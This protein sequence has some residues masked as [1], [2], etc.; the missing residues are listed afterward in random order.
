MS[1]L[2]CG[3]D[4]TIFVMVWVKPSF[5]VCLGAFWFVVLTC[6]GCI[7]G[8][9]GQWAGLETL[10]VFPIYLFD[11][12]SYF[13]S[14]FKS[15]ECVVQQ[16]SIQSLCRKSWQFCCFWFGS[17]DNSVA[18]SLAVFQWGGNNTVT[19]LRTSGSCSQ[20]EISREECSQVERFRE[21]SSH[22]EIF[23]K[24]DS[25]WRRTRTGAGKLQV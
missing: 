14:F 17:R 3:R 8:S 20:V 10:I 21:K 2:G 25:K 13:L 23:R 12:Q 9:G 19:W 4:E 15:Q 1:N 6:R 24:G 22:V 7:C 18:L 16:C 11:E 5:C